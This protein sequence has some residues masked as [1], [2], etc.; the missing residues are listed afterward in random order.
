MKIQLKQFLY[1]ILLLVAN[2][3]YAQD[4]NEI[5][6][7]IY[8]HLEKALDLKERLD[9]KEAL[10]YC[11]EALTLSLKIKDKEYEA[12]TYRVM[13]D[14][15]MLD[16]NL[17]G[18][19]TKLKKASQIQKSN[20]YKEELAITRNT[21]GLV[22]TDLHNYSQALNYFNSASKLYQELQLFSNNTSILKNIGKLYL[23]KGDYKKANET[24]DQAY[25]SSQKF[26]RE[27]TKAEI[28]LFKSQALI[29]LNE[30]SEAINSC[31][32]AIDI[33]NANKYPWIIIE[34]YKTLSEIYEE[35]GNPTRAVFLLKKHNTLRDSIY[36]IEDQRLS[37]EEIARFNFA[38]QG[39]RIERQ[40]LIIQQKEEQEERN[41]IMTFL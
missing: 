30:T 6:D 22:H 2:S 12:K 29:K 41:Q 18:A 9:Y 1:I 3:L 32:K 25:K 34:G 7:Q 31:N 35:S 19:L 28:L 5:E 11:D 24:F 37:A 8:A 23:K 38:A 4:K 15:L 17:S 26:A 39:R 20:N 40:N 10:V 14:I 13:G 21:Q 27:Y 36:S 33:G 16:N